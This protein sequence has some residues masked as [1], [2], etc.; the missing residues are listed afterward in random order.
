MALKKSMTIKDETK[1][2]HSNIRFLSLTT[3]RF[4]KESDIKCFS[5]IIKWQNKKVISFQF[6]E[7]LTVCRKNV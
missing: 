2:V 6:Y 4:L 5:I 1:T 7:D 3:V